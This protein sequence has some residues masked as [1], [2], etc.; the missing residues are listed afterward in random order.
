MKQLFIAIAI[1]CHQ[2]NKKW[3]ELN[4]DFTQKD[5][6]EAEQWQRDY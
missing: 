6:S 2:A 1:A 3:C 4:G 5:W